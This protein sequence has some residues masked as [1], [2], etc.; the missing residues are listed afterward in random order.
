[1]RERF[2]E[3]RTNG[4]ITFVTG[5]GAGELFDHTFLLTERVALELHRARLELT[6]RGDYE[7]PEACGAAGGTA[8]FKIAPGLV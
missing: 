4:D 1:L 2:V 3:V 7:E 6:V 8:V 5:V